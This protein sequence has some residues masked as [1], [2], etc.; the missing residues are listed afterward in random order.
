[1]VLVA[2]AAAMMVFAQAQE[3]R[4]ANEVLLEGSKA[5]EASAKG[6]AEGTYKKLAA[7]YEAAWRKMTPAEAGAGWLA[8]YD[9]SKKEEFSGSGMGYGSSTAFSELPH[10]DSWP[11]IADGLRSRAGTAETIEAIGLRLLAE[12]LAGDPQSQWKAMVPLMNAKITQSEILMYRTRLYTT[13]AEMTQD[14][15]RIVRGFQNQTQQKAPSYDNS[16]QVPDLVSL[17]GPVR[18]EE[19]LIQVLT[20]TKADLQP[21]TSKATNALLRKVASQNMAKLKVAQFSLIDSPDSYLLFEQ[22][23]KRFPEAGE[24]EDQNLNQQRGYYVMGLLFAGRR[25]EAVKEGRALKDTSYYAPPSETVEIS[26]RIAVNPAF[27]ETLQ[28]IVVKNP[29]SG[30]WPLYISAAFTAKK[31]DQAIA[32]L[33]ETLKDAGSSASTLR[34]YLEPLLLGTP[35]RDEVITAVRKRVLDGT[36]DEQ[37]LSRLA[38][39]G[40]LMEKPEWIDEAYKAA[41]VGSKSERSYYGYGG[42]SPLW[43]EL[44][45]GGRYAQ[46]EALLINDYKKVFASEY[47]SSAY[48]NLVALCELY[49][50]M[51]RPADVLLL[52]EKSPDWGAVNIEDLNSYSEASEPF[53]FI[54]AWALHKAGREAEAEKL[55]RSALSKSPTFDPAYALFIEMK[56]EAAIADLDAMYALNQFEE[57]PLIWKAQVLKNLGRLEEAEATARKAISVDPSDGDQTTGDR[58]KAYALLADI[59]EA[60]G[61][62]E[63]AGHLRTAVSA[64]RLAEKADQFMVAGLSDQGIELYKESLQQFS[65][66]YC[67]QSRLAVQLMA[68]GRPEEAEEHYRRAYELM[69]DSF[70][71]VETHCFGCEGVFEGELSQAIAEQ[72]FTKLLETSPNKPQV[73]YLLGYLREEQGRNAEAAKLYQE[74]VKLDPDYLN[75]WRHL[76][77]LLPDLNADQAMVKQVTDALLRLDATGTNSLP[78]YGSTVDLKST[79]IA[80]EKVYQATAKS[81]GPLYTFP[82][83]KAPDEASVITDGMSLG[84]RGGMYRYDRLPGDAVAQHALIANL[85]AMVQYSQMEEESEGMPH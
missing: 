77:A 8:L 84:G 56:G 41:L 18:A 48:S 69:P 82:A 83:V 9:A 55:V 12:F 60:R 20:T 47:I 15:E 29:A 33:E 14:K 6:P 63:E 24:D 28:A 1:M 70:G 35:R 58:L 21:S 42:V 76:A 67:I 19:I 40:R 49:Y 26:A 10:P 66:A 7:D 38:L 78:E 46:A 68:A 81:T 59:R 54:A 80:A 3:V 72:V 57:R 53:T 5:R 31:N 61:D 51:N 23:L 75:A 36:F 65:D 73:H 79:W 74:A 30:F 64:I 52:M 85:L 2:M 13:L 16:V 44:A 71:R 45:K 25:D 11:V 4:G 17:V 39:L 32:A 50:R 22:M 37:D 62:K 34:G 27:L 43:E